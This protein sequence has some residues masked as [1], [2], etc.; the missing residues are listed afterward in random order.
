MYNH[1]RFPGHLSPIDTV[2]PDI[3]LY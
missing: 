3:E 1:H 2:L